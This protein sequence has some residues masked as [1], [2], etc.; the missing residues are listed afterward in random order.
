MRHAYHVLDV[1]T[2][3]ALAGNPL[4]VVL[5]AGD[6][7]DDRAQAIAREFNLSET[8]FVQDPRDPV[9]MRMRAPASSAAWLRIRARVG[10]GMPVLTGRSAEAMRGRGLSARKLP[11]PSYRRSVSAA[12]PWRAHSCATPMLSSALSVLP[13]RKMPTPTTFASSSTRST[14]S[15]YA[16]PLPRKTCL[17][18]RHRPPA[19]CAHSCQ[20][21]PVLHDVWASAA[22]GRFANVACSVLTGYL[23]RQKARN[24]K[25]G[26]RGSRGV[27]RVPCAR[28]RGVPSL[29][30]AARLG[31]TTA[32][33]GSTGCSSPGRTCPLRR[34]SET[35]GVMLTNAPAQ[36]VMP[37][38]GRRQD[39]P[40]HRSAVGCYPGYEIIMIAAAMR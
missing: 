14:S 30:N 13:V 15:L 4:G 2:D 12:Q 20:F 25:A 5:E 10:R 19:P 31:L 37:K 29:Y 38:C 34:G 39:A 28:T 40:P 36:G 8:V 18:C 32:Y 7:P 6:I 9:N 24:K 3:T 22:G 1:F 23:H 11:A 35:S 33:R 27:M 16:V 21:I 26:C 17:R